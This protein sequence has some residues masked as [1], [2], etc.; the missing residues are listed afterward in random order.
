M[1]RPGRTLPSGKTRYPLY[2]RLGGPMAGLD[3]YGKSRP[4]RDSILGAFNHATTK[5]RRQFVATSG[6]VIRGPL[7]AEACS[8]IIAIQNRQVCSSLQRMWNTW[9]QSPPFHA[10]FQFPEEVKDPTVLVCRAALL[11]S[12]QQLGGSLLS[13][14]KPNCQFIISF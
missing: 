6:H 13:V 5:Y 11:W 8:R 4:H 2:R 1:P 7:I 9:R 12:T 10:S 14:T 3:R